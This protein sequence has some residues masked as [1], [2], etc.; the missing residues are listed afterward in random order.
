[1]SLSELWELVMD[2]EAWHA[3]IH[4]VAKSRT[5]L[6]DWTELT[7]KAFV[8]FLCRD[9][10]LCCCSWWPLTPSE[11]VEGAICTPGDVVGQ[12]FRD[13]GVFPVVQSLG[14]VWFLQL[15]RLQHA[16]ISCPSL[17]PRACSNSSP[18]SRWCHP[19]ISSSVIPFSSVLLKTKSSCLDQMT[20]ISYWR[21]KS[22][23]STLHMH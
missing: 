5:R 8:I 17:S 19:I 12:V 15:H 9:W 4:G 13:L 11:G 7:A 6:S 3:A 10:T 20:A 18:L 22:H 23:S 21:L 14:H 1:M 2:K 16:R